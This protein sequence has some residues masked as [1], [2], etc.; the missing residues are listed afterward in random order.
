MQNKYMKTLWAP[1]NSTFQ[2]SFILGRQ[3]TTEAFIHILPPPPLGLTVA[4]YIFQLEQKKILWLFYCG[5]FAAKMS[6]ILLR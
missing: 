5:Y 1:D 6:I 4:F 2:P 3:A